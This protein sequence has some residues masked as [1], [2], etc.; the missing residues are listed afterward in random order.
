MANYLPPWGEFL[1][2]GW[3]KGAWSIAGALLGLF[4][5]CSCIDGCCWVLLMWHCIG[6]L[7]GGG[8]WVLLQMHCV[9]GWEAAAVALVTQVG[10][11]VG[12]TEVG[13]TGG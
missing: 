1:R 3:S 6:G 4:G 7:V 8:W 5:Y 10:M 9:G 2:L 11:W 12:S 13:S